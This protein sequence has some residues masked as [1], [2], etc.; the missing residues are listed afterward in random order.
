MSS[1][2][3]RLVFRDPTSFRKLAEVSVRQD[4]Q[5]V[6]NLN[7]LACVDGHVYANVWTQDSLVRIDP[8]TGRVT[9]RI[10]AGGL[11]PT[12]D[13]RGG[14]DVLNGIA[15]LPSKQRFL[16]DGQELAVP[17]RGDVRAD[18][19]LALTRAPGQPATAAQ[20]RNAPR[21]TTRVGPP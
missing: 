9:A 20:Q 3:D 2:S 14:E 11:L 18:L 7:E 10:D 6:R 16:A 12:S 15:Y 1:G 17:V 19:R 8:T 13:R 21:E 5:P 4:G